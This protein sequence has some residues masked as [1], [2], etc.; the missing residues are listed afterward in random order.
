MEPVIMLP[1]FRSLTMG[2][3]NDQAQWKLP[4]QCIAHAHHGDLGDI[5]VV[6]YHLTVVGKWSIKLQGL[7]MVTSS[8]TSSIAP[9]LSLCPAT[10]STS[11]VRDITNT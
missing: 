8:I 9:E 6:G 2:V 7:A 10:F 3:Q 11:S 1:P 4:S 5:G